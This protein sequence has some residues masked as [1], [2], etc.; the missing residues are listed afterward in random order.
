[1]ARC[2]SCG[3]ELPD[4]YTS[5]PNCGGTDLSKSPVSAAPA[6]H[7]YVPISQQREVTSAGGW[8]CW[9]LLLS[10]L[11]IIGTIIMLCTVKDPTAKN[12]AKLTLIMQIIGIVL[13][14]ILIM[15][16]VPTMMGYVE[17]SR[18]V[19]SGLMLLGLL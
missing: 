4:Y 16:L 9:Y 10:F 7:S 17:K 19:H 8:F 14:I 5:C 18:A 2:N 1:M 15:I 13:T 3:A 12:Y 11:P 6:S